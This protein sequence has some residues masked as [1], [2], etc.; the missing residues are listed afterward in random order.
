MKIELGSFWKFSIEKI[1]VFRLLI[2]YFL[3]PPYG[4]KKES[5]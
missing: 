3:F 2:Y 1:P 5:S 4:K